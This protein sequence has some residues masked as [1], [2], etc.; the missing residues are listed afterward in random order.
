MKNTHARLDI[1]LPEWKKTLIV[2][3]DDAFIYPEYREWEIITQVRE[4]GTM[5]N[6]IGKLELFFFS[7]ISLTVVS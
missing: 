7:T 3:K 1:T 5:K 2:R 4:T 6:K